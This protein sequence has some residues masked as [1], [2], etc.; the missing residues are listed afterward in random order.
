MSKINNQL[1]G[2][3]GVYFV[4]SELS[5]RGFIALP[6]VRNTVGIDLVV[7]STDG[8]FQANLQ[9]KTSFQRVSS[10]WP[11]GNNYADFNWKGF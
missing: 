5:R 4:A 11:V 7:A 9:V 10:P 3:A 6:T 1:I 8:S 2:M